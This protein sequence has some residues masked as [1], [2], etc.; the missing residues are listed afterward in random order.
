MQFSALH[1]AYKLAMAGVTPTIKLTP[2]TAAGSR[3]VAKP[4]TEAASKNNAKSWF[5]SIAFPSPMNQASTA[6]QK[7]DNATGVVLDQSSKQVVDDCSKANAKIDKDNQNAVF[8]PSEQDTES[9]ILS[10]S[11]S[12]GSASSSDSVAKVN[13]SFKPTSEQALSTV[14]RV[15]G[16]LRAYKT[17]DVMSAEDYLR[18]NAQTRK[19]RKEKV[20]DVVIYYCSCMVSK[21]PGTM[22]LT[23]YY[24]AFTSGWALAQYREILPII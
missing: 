15:R 6:E 23:P 3:E 22:Y 7:K 17:Y 9:L 21:M 4:A 8:F 16:R 14:E 18:A 13:V 11:V 20:L 24:L 12:A 19:Y 1:R 5:S 2:P 10:R